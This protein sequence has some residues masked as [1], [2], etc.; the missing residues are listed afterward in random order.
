[1]TKQGR[2]LT[3]GWGVGAMK[4]ALEAQAIIPKKF[5]FKGLEMRLSWTFRQNVN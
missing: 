2:V 5:K 3:G 4:R 1:M